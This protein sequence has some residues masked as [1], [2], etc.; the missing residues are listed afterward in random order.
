MASQKL[1]QRRLH[2]LTKQRERLEA[3][4]QAL[5][6]EVKTLVSHLH[7]STP[8]TLLHVHLQESKAL[9]G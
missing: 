8:R 7:A 4:L 3:E 6:A 2:M 1:E 9:D 5:E